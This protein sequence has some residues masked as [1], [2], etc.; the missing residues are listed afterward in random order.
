MSWVRID[1][2]APAH[3][4][5]LAAGAEA[6]WFWVCGS[7]WANKQKESNGFIPEAAL[8]ILYPAKS[9]KKIADKLVACGLWERVDG[10]YQIHDYNEYQLTREQKLALSAKRAD[11]GRTGG[12]KKAAN[13]KQATKQVASKLLEHDLASGSSK[14]LAI[15][16]PIPSVD[17]STPPKPPDQ[18]VFLVRM[19]PDWKPPVETVSGLIAAGIPEWASMQLAT[20]YA[21]GWSAKPEKREPEKWIETFCWWAPGEWQKRKNRMKPPRETELDEEAME[22]RNFA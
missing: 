7:A 14:P 12:S 16:I 5:I 18:E 21:V 8:P 2:V 19:T 6:A 22:A 9:P 17:K 11:A 15:P 3:P 4:K 13:S 20:I 10:G 1:D